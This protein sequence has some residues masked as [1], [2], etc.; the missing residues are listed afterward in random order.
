[1]R[2]LIIILFLCTNLFFSQNTKEIEV[3]F[4]D[5]KKNN[6][7]VDYY[8]LRDNKMELLILKKSKI[9]LPYSSEKKEIIVIA[10]YNNKCIEFYIK[11]EEI[12]YLKII[13]MPFSFKNIFRNKYVI[14]QGLDYEEIVKTKKCR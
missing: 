6:L 5:N 4:I 11:P 12:E 10:V 1:M 9:S 8:L 7:N 2:L 13:R 14:N 3:F